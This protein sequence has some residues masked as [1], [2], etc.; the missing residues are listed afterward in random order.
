MP[1]AMF[2]RPADA[3]DIE[4]HLN[5]KKHKVSDKFPATTTLNDYIRDVAGLSG[6][7]VMCK[8]AGCGCCAV[9]VTHALDGEVV[10]TMSINSCVCPL[11]SVDGWQITTTE[12]IGNHKGGLHPIQERLVDQNGTQCGYCSPG[13]VMSM[14]GL[15]HQQP[16]PTMSEIEGSLDGHICRCTGYRSILDAMKSFGVDSPSG[17]CIDI[18]DLNKNLCPKTGE[19]CHGNDGCTSHGVKRGSNDKAAG[20]DSPKGAAPSALDLDLRESRWYRPLTLKDIGKILQQHKT[21]SIKMVFGNTA[22]GIFKHQGPF[23]VYIDLRSVKELHIFKDNKTSIMF[24]AGTTIGKFRKRLIELGEKPGFHYFPRVVRHLN[25][26]ASVLVRNAGSMAGNLMIKHTNPWFPSDLFTMLEAIGAKIDIFDSKTGKTTKH[27]LM[28]F[29][30]KVDMKLKVITAIE[31]PSWTSKD[32]YR[33]FKITPR[34]Q[35]AHAYINAAFKIPVEQRKIVGRPNIVIGGVSGEMVHAVMTEAFLDKKTLTDEVVNGALKI[36]QDEIQPE[37]LEVGGSPQYR[38][39]LSVNLLYK[40]LLE[41]FQPMKFSLQSGALSMERPLSSGLQTYQQRQDRLP[42]GQG[43][44]KKTAPL[45]V[46]GEA[47]YTNDLPT[48][49]DELQAAFVGTT[50]A[51]GKIDKIDTSE[52]MKI[53]GVLGFISAEDIPPEGV[54]NFIPLNNPFFPFKDE[55]FVSEEVD[56]AGKPVGIVLAESQA[57]AEQGARAVKITYKD[58]E[59]PIMDVREAVQKNLFHEGCHESKERGDVQAALKEA[60]YVVE[61]ECEMGTQYHFYI[62]NQVALCVPSEDGMD[63][64]SATQASDLVHRTTSQVLGKPMNY[65]NIFVNRLGGSFGGKFLNSTAVTASAAVAAEVTG[66]PVRLNVDLAA[67]MKFTSKRWPLLAKYKAGCDRDGKLVA[68]DIN[69]YIDSGHRPCITIDLMNLIECAYH[70]VNFR[71]SL[72]KC[73]TNKTFAGPVRG[74]GQIPGCLIMETILEHL[75]KEVKQDPVLLREINLQEDGQPTITGRTLKNVTIKKVWNR[76]K[77]TAN[78]TSRQGDISRFNK[79]NLWRKRGL[80]MTAVRY[81][82]EY[83]PPGFPSHISIFA[84]DGTV[85]VFTG[86]VEMGQGLYMKV[87]QAVAYRLKIPVDFVKVRPNQ[88]NVTPNPLFTGGSITSERSVAS[89]LLACDQINERLQPVREKFPDADWKNLIANA[90]AIAIDLSAEATSVHSGAELVPYATYMAGVVETE[91]DVLTGEFQ[92]KRVDMM[93]DFGE[94]MNPTID[95]GQVEGAF[96]MG[97]GAY[98]TEDIFYSKETGQLLNDGTWEYKPPTTKDIPIDWRIHFLP[99][100]PNTSGILSSKAVGEPPIG[101]AMGALLAIK[102]GVYSVR[103]DLSGDHTFLPINAPLTV[104]KAQMAS[105]IQTKYLHVGGTN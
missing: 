61:G 83:F 91:V 52:A 44:P 75:S 1:K 48:F 23:E 2:I 68:I 66:R 60:A 50:I 21:H 36:M 96:V 86:G 25:V 89:V 95:I 32:H 54:N 39:Q 47:K 31:V 22:S 33:S 19:P 38:R 69:L 41:V 58:V 103:E 76:L 5:G 6:T 51:R 16:K 81:D 30:R 94:S 67:N 79:N 59:K 20:N 13:F 4:F 71:L 99:D 88:N 62:E 26:L 56:Y 102:Q 98:L 72:E 64:Y 27:T 24:G 74:P 42:L 73:Y 93:A 104:E 85:T 8:E 18:E 105:S 84:G 53:P 80:A 9:T 37:V 57:L 92:V 3:A 43:L 97:L 35:N 40:T 34:W 10:E 14:Y 46:T 65:C 17:K 15:L 101:L 45:Q 77:Q 70:S 49:Q 63:I 28:D 78:V 12:G 29:L 55:V 82:M 90:S 87:A 100:T 11:Y 7:K